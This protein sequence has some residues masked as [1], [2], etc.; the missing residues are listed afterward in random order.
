MLYTKPDYFDQ[1]KCIADKCQDTC[2]SGWQIVIDD[3]KLEEYKSGKYSDIDMN[4]YVDFEEGVFRQHDDRRC[5][6]LQDDNLCKLCAEHGE[7]SLCRTCHLYPRHIEEFENVRETTLSLSCPEVAKIILSRKERVNFISEEDET[8][9]EDEEF[10][11]LLYSMLL[12][13]RDEMIKL[14][15]NRAVPIDIRAGMILG[16]CH[17]IDKRM[18]DGRYHTIPDLL[19]YFSTSDAIKKSYEK[20]ETFRSDKSRMYDFM[21]KKFKKLI[22]L[23]PIGYDWINLYSEAEYILYKDGEENYSEWTRR[24]EK[25]MK[26]MDV[27]IDVQME[28]IL[29]YFISTYFCGAVYDGDIYGKGKLCVLSAFYIKEFW[30][31]AFIK[32]NGSLSEEEKYDLALRFSRELEHSD[33]NLDRI[34]KF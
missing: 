17:D 10:D 6:F 8:F 21:Q 27:S 7:E 12:D 30:K 4:T 32:N 26:I 33:E 20:I 9:E 18:G 5:M 22:K 25:K 24:F 29:V 2:C 13:A 34:V 31:A 3:E 28:Q 23:E 1:F 16:L 19:E 14:L 15:Q 11:F